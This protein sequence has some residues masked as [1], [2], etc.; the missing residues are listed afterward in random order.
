MLDHL[1]VIITA[2]CVAIPPTI[3]A[4]AALI[5]TVRTKADVTAMKNGMKDLSSRSGYQAGQL[6]PTGTPYPEHT[7][8][9]K[10][11]GS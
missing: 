9:I 3:A 4:I 1:D 10:P 7:E 6:A 2:I 8:P 5:V 11:V